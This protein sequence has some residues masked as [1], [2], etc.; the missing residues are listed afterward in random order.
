MFNDEYLDWVFDQAHRA[1]LGRPDS[2]LDMNPSTTSARGSDGELYGECIRAMWYKKMG[3]PSDFDTD[4][5]GFLIMDSGTAIGAHIAKYF[6]NCGVAVAP[7]GTADEQR[8]LIERQTKAGNKYRIS[9]RIDVICR[10][11]DNGLIGYEFKTVWSA[12]KANRVIKGYRCIPEAD[13]KNV[14]Q[15][16]MYAD[17]GRRF[18]GILDWRLAYIYVEGK[19]GKVYHISVDNDGRI[20]VDGTE[21]PFSLNDAYAQYDKLADALIAGVPPD[22]DDELWLSSSTLLDMSING[23]LTKDQAERYD[24]GLKVLKPWS[25]CTYCKYIGTCLSPQDAVDAAELRK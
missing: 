14:M 8:V 18:L 21:Q 4:V 25:A 1:G 12:K 9:G 10:G 15:T 19:V 7:N 20:F 3:T 6:M 22:R 2:L 23:K 24:A 5:P 16:A 13:S 17:F 11:P